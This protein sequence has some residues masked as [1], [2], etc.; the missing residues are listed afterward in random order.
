MT[1]IPVL[2]SKE[3]IS[4]LKRHGFEMENGHGDGG[5]VRLV[6]ADCVVHIPSHGRAQTLSQ[7][8]LRILRNQLGVSREEFVRLMTEPKKK[9]QER[10]ESFTVYAVTAGCT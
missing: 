10:C 8:A 3:V 4:A 5:H 7:P 9:A 2:K 1:P 6:R